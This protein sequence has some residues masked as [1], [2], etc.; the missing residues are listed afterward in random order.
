MVPVKGVLSVSYRKILSAMIGEHAT[1]RAATTR[2]CSSWLPG[3]YG[4]TSYVSLQNMENN[5]GGASVD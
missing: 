1:L 2:R 3:V 5:V 4:E